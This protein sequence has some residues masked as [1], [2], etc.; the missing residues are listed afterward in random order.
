MT[1]Q[2]HA[3]YRRM[4]TPSLRK[5]N[6]LVLGDEMTRL[7]NEEIATWPIGNTFDLWARVRHLMHTFAI[8]LLFG[9]DRE[10]GYP[11]ADMITDVLARKWSPSVMACPINLP[12]TPYG[13]MLKESNVLERCILEW[14]D[15]K[16]GHFE[17]GDLL[18]IIV[19]NPEEDGKPILDTTIVGLMPQLFGAAFET[20][21]LA[22]SWTLVLIA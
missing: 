13:Q 18:S 21:Q 4:L 11:T 1:G 16:H 5:A 3:H 12:V 8:G 15:T 14:A 7:A 20:C 19:N 10:H 9:N 17:G 22:L 2:R 6:V